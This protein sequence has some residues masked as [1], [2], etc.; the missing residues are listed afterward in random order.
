MVGETIQ[1][2]RET[3]ANAGAIVEDAD[4]QCKRILEDAEKEA[5]RLKEEQKDMVYQK[6]KS[7][8]ETTMEQGEQSQRDAMSEI[9]NEIKLLK[10]AASKKEEEAVKIVVSQLV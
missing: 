3:E 9:E 2:I 5:E 6:A 4:T 7:M 1:A 8:M 10:E